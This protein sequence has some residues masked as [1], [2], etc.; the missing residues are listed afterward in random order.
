MRIVVLAGGIGGARFLLGVRAWARRHDGAE[1]TAVVNVG[2]DVTLHGLRICPDL[3]SVMYTLGGGADPERGWGRAGETWTVKEELAAYGAEPTW[4]GLGDQDVATHLVRTRMLDAGYPLSAVTE[5]L[6]ARWQPGVTLL[7]ATDDRLETHVVVDVDGERRGDPLPGVV[8]PPP[9]R[10]AGPAV[11]LRRRRDGQAGRR[12]ARRARRGRRGAA[13]AEQPGGEHRA[14][15][16]RGRPARRAGRPARRRSSA[17]RR[18]SAAR[19]CAAWPTSAWP[20]SASSAARPA[21]AG[22]TAP[23]RDGGVL[24]GWLVDPAD[25]GTTVPGVDGTRGSTVDDRR[26]GHGGDGRARPSTW[27]A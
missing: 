17:S 4:F 23:A 3:D 1:V 12:R 9:R 18:S 2:D 25:A 22:S 20:R 6:C 21:S 26:D 19:R 16:R 24:D 14:D 8:G 13:R 11:R 27:R 15:P 7:P 5:A 10:A